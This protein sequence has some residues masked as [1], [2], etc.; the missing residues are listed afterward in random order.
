MSREVK[1][2][3][4]VLDF[5]YGYLLIK[6]YFLYIKTNILKVNYPNI[7]YANKWREYVSKVNYNELIKK[8]CE[9]VT[10]INEVIE[11]NWLSLYDCLDKSAYFALIHENHPNITLGFTKDADLWDIWLREGIFKL[12]REIIADILSLSNGDKV[13]DLGCGSASPTFYGEII[14]PN[15]FY[16]GIDFSK[17]LLSLA[18]VRVRKK[19]LDWVKLN[20]WYVD[21]KIT[22]SESYDYVI[23]SSILQYTNFKM[24]L[25]NAIRA[26]NGNGVIIVFSEVFTD[27]EP[28]RAKLFELYYSLI[29]SFKGFPSISD[30]LNYIHN[31]C[32]YKCKLIG[33]NILK[34]EI[35]DSIVH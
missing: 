11:G 16:T 18:K 9:L 21:S 4:N 32:E 7:E 5:I 31:Y 10:N 20:Q 35:M 29:P 27:L 13:I 34:L 30:I 22:F 14:G 1:I 33:K 8:A 19:N 15:G 3:N 23:C 17:P 24:A 6:S 25:N 28:E 12:V 2:L 26:L